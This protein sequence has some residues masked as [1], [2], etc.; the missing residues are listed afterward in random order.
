MNL[1]KVTLANA[2]RRLKMEIEGKMSDAVL[3]E[4]KGQ[5]AVITINQ[6][7]RR[8][9]LGIAVR[10]GLFD[11]WDRFEKDPEAKVAILAGTG[12]EGLL[13]SAWTSGDERDHAAHSAAR[14]GA[15][16]RSTTS[17]SPSRPSPR[18]TASPS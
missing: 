10:Q 13:L 8:N 2:R 5:V 3:Y 15:G 14:A 11:A 4:M 12:E 18:S 7:D 9:A 6:P 17:S 1:L 16:D